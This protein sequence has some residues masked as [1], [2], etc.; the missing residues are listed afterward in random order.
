MRIGLIIVMSAKKPDESELSTKVVGWL[1]E[2]GYP[3][4]MRVAAALRR[5][6]PGASGSDAAKIEWDHDVSQ[7]WHYEDQ[8]TGKS[9]ELDVLF[10]HRDWLGMAEIHFCV[11]CKSTSKP[12]VLFTSNERESFNRML[13]FCVSSDDARRALFEAIT[14]LLEAVPWF[15]KTGRVGYGITEAFTRSD[16]ATRSAIL[17]ATKASVSLVTRSNGYSPPFLFAFPVVVISSRLFECYLAPNGDLE[18]N[19]VEEGW[20]HIRETFPGFSWTCVRV[21]TVSGLE[22]FCNE[23]AETTSTLRSA[24]QG[25]IDQAWMKFKIKNQD[26]H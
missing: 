2:Q 26:P 11:E 20:L 19:E 9:R 10:S 5:T 21:V 8:D 16:D 13:G 4:E 15:A 25:H 17:G 1:H 23:V 3:L 12:W 14:H 24:L 18:V 22:R 7:S 6:I